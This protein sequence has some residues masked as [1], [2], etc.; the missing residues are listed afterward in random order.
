[1]GI[2]IKSTKQERPESLKKPHVSKNV[3]VKPKKRVNYSDDD[4]DDDFIVKCKKMRS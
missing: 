2:P 3:D 1:M 4:D